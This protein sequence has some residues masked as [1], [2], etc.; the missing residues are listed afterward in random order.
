M[1]ST[2]RFGLGGALA[3][4]LLVALIAGCG[5][6]GGNS[7]TSPTAT[8][9]TLTPSSASTAVGASIT[10]TA[11]VSPS[12]VTGSVDFYDSTTGTDLGS[13]SLSSGTATLNNVSF[14]ATGTHNIKATYGGNSTYATSY[15]TASVTVNA[16]AATTTTLSTGLTNNTT[17]TGASITLTATISAGSGTATSASGTVTFYNGTTSLGTGTLSSGTATLSNI[18]FSSA[19]TYSLTAVYSGDST[20]ATSTSSTVIVNVNASGTTATTVTLSAST[21][22]PPASA[23]M[24]LTAK[25]YDSTGATLETGATGSV[26]FY[27]STTS[28]D[29]G[30]ASVSAGVATLSPS[31]STAG[32]S[33]AVYATYMGDETY[34]ESSQSNTVDITVAAATNT[35]TITLSVS[36]TTVTAGSGVALAAIVTPATSTGTVTF[37]DNGTTEIGTPV[38]LSDTAVAAL[39]T[40]TLAPG[41]HT[42]TAVYDLMTS[43]TA[44][45]QVNTATAGSFTRNAACGYSTDHT[46]TVNTT[47]DYVLASGTLSTIGGN[48]DLESGTDEN[49]ICVE[50]TGAYLTLINPTI[51]SKSVEGSNQDT[52]ASWYGVNAAVLDY[53]GGNLTI[54]G[55]TITSEGDG[56][57]MVDSYGTGTITISNST[58]SS[59]N[60]NQNNH[61]IFAANHGAVVANNVTASSTGQNSSIVATDN[62]GGTLTING[63]HYTATG[64]HSD[65]IYSTGAVTAYNATFSSNNSAAVIEGDNSINLNNVTLNVPEG[66]SAQTGIFLYQ[67][68]SGDA[69]NHSSTCES[70]ATG[71]CFVMTNGTINFFNT[72]T[73]NTNPSQN[74]T[75]FEVF[76]QT[77][78]VILSDVTVNNSCGTLLLSSWNDQWSNSNQYGYATFLVYGTALTGDV[79]VGD[80][81][82]DSTCATRDTSST[83]AITL[84]AD[85][86]GNG[87]SLTGAINPTDTGQTASLTLDP[88]SYWRVT[89]TSYLTNL[90]ES[91]GDT[92]YSN[93]TCQT[94]GCQVYVNGTA[95]SIATA[96]SSS[97][98]LAA[99]PTT[100]SPGSLTILTATVSP[101]SATGKVTFYDNTSA[102]GTA[103]LSSGTATLATHFSS[104]GSHTLSAVYSGDFS[105]APSTSTTQSESVNAGS[106]SLD[107][108]SYSYTAG[109]MT[110]NSH[111]VDYLFYQNVV[112]AANPV[113][114]QYESMNLFIPTSVDGIAVSGAQPIMLDINVGGFMSNSVW[115]NTGWQPNDSNAPYA[116]GK[117]YIVAQVGCRGRDLQDF[118]GAYYGKAPAAIVDL[119]A[120]VRFL[121]YNYT[122]GTFTGDVDHIFS[123]GGSAG[124]ALSSLLGASG[125]SPL[126]DSYLAEIG[127]ADADDNIFA[128]GAWSPVVDLDHTDMTY[129]WI[130]GSLN[131]Q[132]GPVNSVISQELQTNFQSYENS[133][134][135]TGMRGSYGALTY[136]NIADYILKEYME[137]SLNKY[138]QSG[139]SAPSYATCTGT[140]SSESCTFTFS[141]Y[142]NDSVGQRED[143][144]PAYD[145]FFDLASSS[146]LTG[147]NTE[148]TFSVQ[149]FGNSTINARHFT[150]FSS[151]YVDG[152]DIDSDIPSLVN[153]MNPMYFLENAIASGDTSGVAKYWYI[154]DGAIATTTSAIVIANLVTI[155]EDLW[156]T[157]NVNAAEDWNTGHNVNTDP[158]GFSTWVTNSIA[159]N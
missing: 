130:Y 5:S 26:D 50:G 108:S 47:G 119:K 39:T 113:N 76:N 20:Y 116:L 93:I 33:H 46:T 6:G 37:Y 18:S 63:G 27:D 88:A 66:T 112:Y 129:E 70:F 86:A 44:T 1:K 16:L 23:S 100:V 90:T 83:A 75:A 89:G 147:V 32:S 25:V 36:P 157:S 48:Y 7:S 105:Y 61:G 58:L 141:D 54:D 30:T 59:P 67:S 34:A 78:L 81:C 144:V 137:P 57:N 22:T 127:A 14:S 124:G 77:S 64:F 156:G 60:N 73:G 102:L 91:D 118:T 150:N 4:L 145:S 143:S 155:V 71:D 49:A 53:N 84:N 114:N 85:Q 115:N 151:Q 42:I 10:L 95:I 55:A 11:T 131:T 128:V 101:S 35:N 142:L 106:Y 79:I 31:F 62:N 117:G 97:T 24:T 69:N 74:C 51:I 80:G 159:A 152:K 98:V 133:L 28:T 120:A 41:P 96:A 15:G 19:G 45:V 92:K 149:E 3:S 138:V 13:A 8:S 99:S 72:V 140:G 104:T 132:T 154:R 125:N 43:N 94:S 134:N 82:L 122:A 38:N 110:A 158:R 107:L 135:L 139:N 2:R 126:Y 65:G 12:A 29:L 121:R 68:M 153:M 87:S 103:Q 123:S 17:T 40:T 148:E 111:S 136:S 56:A 9:T 109:T 146:T 21:T 52:D